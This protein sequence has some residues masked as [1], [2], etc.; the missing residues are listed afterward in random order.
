M[1]ASVGFDPARRLT[2]A[3]LFSTEEAIARFGTPGEGNGAEQRLVT[4]QAPYK[5]RLYERGAPLQVERIRCHELV[6]DWVEAAL[7]LTL[8]TYGAKRIVKLGLDVY[9]G[10]YVPRLMRNSKKTW[11]KHAFGIAFD[12]LPKENGNLTPFDRATFSRPEYK[13]WLDCWRCS[14]FANLGQ[15]EGIGRDA[16]HFEFMKSP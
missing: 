8:N 12:F 11:S 15:V 14:G 4:I 13:E 2:K 5:M 10:S 16:M 3:D 9:A 7:R 1:I 6:A